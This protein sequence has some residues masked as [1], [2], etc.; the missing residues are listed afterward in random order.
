MRT[1]SAGRSRIIGV[2]IAVCVAM[3]LSAVPGVAAAGDTSVTPFVD[4]YRKNTDGSYTVILG[5]TNTSA[6]MSNIPYGSRN[7]MYPAKFHGLQPTKS[8]PGTQRGVF[9]IT[10]T[11]ADLSSNPRW[12]LDGTTL[13]YPALSSAPECPPPTALPAL[14][15][16]T[17][18]AIA[19]VGGGLFGVVFV[20]RMIR[21]AT[22]PVTAPADATA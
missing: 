10:A 7:T 9:S 4:C 6:N 15:N 16:G 5:Y 1:K 3:G 2:L 18:L 13:S 12:V 17:G 22:A 14:G 11:E 19:L 20:R 21:R 8:K